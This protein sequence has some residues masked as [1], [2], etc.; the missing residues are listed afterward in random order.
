MEDLH[1]MEDEE[2]IKND[3]AKTTLKELLIGIIA[4]GAVFQATVVWLVERKLSYTAGLWL[5][6]L[7]AAFL[8]WHMWKTLDESLDLETAGAEKNMRKQSLI[9]Y[10]IV[11]AAL[12][13]LMCSEAA[14]PL[15]AFLGVMTLKVAAYLQPFTHKVISKLRR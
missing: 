12:A 2:K 1:L 3:A 13:V 7:L 6:V 11:I 9:R 4:A 10:G 15:A 5:G 8:A 14:N